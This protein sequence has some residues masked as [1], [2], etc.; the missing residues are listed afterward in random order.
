LIE[1]VD[2]ELSPSDFLFGRRS[3]QGLQEH[4]RRR[5]LRSGQRRHSD[6]DRALAGCYGRTDPPSKKIS[7][8]NLRRTRGEIDEFHR[9]HAYS[10]L[11]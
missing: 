7:D 8:E 11:E 2:F 5:E 3:A 4:R 6:T 1:A 10:R 9:S